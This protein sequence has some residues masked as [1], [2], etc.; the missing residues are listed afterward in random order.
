M[1]K[2]EF[3]APPCDVRFG[4][5]GVS[6][7]ARGYAAT[8]EVPYD[9]WKAMLEAG[10]AGFEAGDLT[11]RLGRSFS[12]PAAGPD[13]LEA[14][15][16]ALAECRRLAVLMAETAAGRCGPASFL[17]EFPPAFDYRPDTRRH[18]DRV[19]K[20]LADLPLS[21]AFFNADWYSSRVIEG[22]KMRGV[23]LCLM[24]APRRPFSPPSID[25]VT[26]PFVY[27]KFYGRNAAAFPNYDYSD[28]ELSAWLPRLRLLAAQ[29]EK[30]RI[31]F[32]AGQGGVGRK[33]A[34]RLAEMWREEA[35]SGAGPEKRPTGPD[36]GGR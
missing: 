31:V 17:L 30:L 36:E 9:E 14:Y 5:V 15:G 8:A 12:R 1:E 29:A 23:C 33:N 18:L 24:D 6:T 21:V 2:G 19:L 4:S 27:V 20:D 13:E 22:L 32:S 7:L 11:V 35:E 3:S 28:A 10:P 34:L 16:L 26:A 25:V